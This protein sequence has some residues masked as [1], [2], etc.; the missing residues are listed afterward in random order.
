[1][2]EEW[3]MCSSEIAFNLEKETNNETKQC[4]YAVSIFFENVLTT[5]D[6]KMANRQI[7]E[8]IFKGRAC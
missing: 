7:N 2:Q 1:M 3:R 5:G 6:S 8:G 4:C